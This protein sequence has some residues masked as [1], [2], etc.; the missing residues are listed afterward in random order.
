MN[1]NP[2]TKPVVKHSRRVWKWATIAAAFLAVFGLIYW[3]EPI[4]QLPIPIS[5]YWND[6]AADVITLTA[7]FAA[8][9]LGIRLTRH[10]KPSEPPHRIWFTFTL[11]WWAW[12]IGELLGFVYDYFYWYSQNPE[13][14]FMDLCW[15]LGY[16]FFGLSLYY[17]FRLIYSHKKGTKTFQYFSLIVLGL[18]LTYGLTELALWGG[19][20]K[21]ASWSANYLSILYPVFD[22]IEGCAALWLF[23]LFGRGY[24]GRPWWGLIAFAVADAINIYFWLGGYEGMSDQIYYLLDLFSNIAYV[25]GYLITALAFLAAH[26]HIERGIT[27]LPAAS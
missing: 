3:Y 16:V 9:M 18:L 7:A 15:L 21:E 6:K 17:Q 26:E 22:L 4:K 5:D 13:F 19:L 1:I 23:F 25:A 12:V 10:F 24:L 2:D 8:A 27:A 11:G 20:G 14:T